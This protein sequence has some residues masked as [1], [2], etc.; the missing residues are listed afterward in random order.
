MKSA[1]DVLITNPKG[2]ILLLKRAPYLKFSPNLWTFPGGKLEKG[3]TPRECAAREAKE[4]T[5]L[6]LKLS[7]Q[8]FCLFFYPNDCECCAELVV[9]VFRADLVGEPAVKIAPNESSEF[10]WFSKT[11]LK[12]LGEKATPCVR[13]VL[14]IIQI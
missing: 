4:E 6:N 1:S 13:E 10:K 9:H 5:G 3:E 14:R 7:E 2:E 8:P 11:E 12:G